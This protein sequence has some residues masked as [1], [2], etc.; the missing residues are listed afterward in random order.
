MAPTQL[1]SPPL[2]APA[3]ITRAD[4]TRGRFMLLAPGAENITR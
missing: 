3:E 4:D 1:D 2:S